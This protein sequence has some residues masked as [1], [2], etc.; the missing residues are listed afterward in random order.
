MSESEH[1]AHGKPLSLPEQTFFLEKKKQGELGHRD[2]PFNRRPIASRQT[3]N[4]PNGLVLF[5]P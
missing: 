1:A 5:P 2:A 4:K 3:A